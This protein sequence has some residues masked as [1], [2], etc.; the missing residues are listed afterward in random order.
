MTRSA[1]QP[2]ARSKPLS[3]LMISPEATPFA[4]TGGLGDVAG[5]LPQAL[6]RLGHRVTLV[7]PRYRGIDAGSPIDQQR[8][9]IGGRPFDVGYLEHPLAEKARA[10]FVDVPELYDRPGLYSVGDRDYPDNALRFAVL[11]RAALELGARM[12]DAWRPSLVHAHEWQAGLVPVYLKTHYARHPR[13][14]GL[15]IVFTIH[16][17]AFQGLFPSETMRSLDLGWE[18]YTPEAL[19]FWG[20]MSFLKGGVN[21]ADRITTVSPRYAREIVSPELGFNFD[22]I[23]RARQAVLSGILNGIDAEGWN[24]ET[25]VHLP[26][27]FGP[28][29][30]DTKREVKRAL[31]E[32]LRLPTDQAALDRPVVGLVSRMTDQKGFDLLGAAMPDLMALDVTFALLGS[33]E[34]RYERQWVRLAA[35]HPARVGAQIAF[36]ESLAHLIVAGADM[37]L[38]PSRF[39]PC[40]LNQ[41]YSL[42]YGTVPVVRATG[43]LADTITN[44]SDKTGKGTG[45][46]FEEY[47]VRALV[48]ALERAIAVYN[49]TRE[50]WRALQL[51]GMAEDHSWDVSAR[52]YVK[53]YRGLF[54]KA[55]SVKPRR[56]TP[57]RGHQP[58]R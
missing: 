32:R 21:F 10:I 18:L 25:D 1:D 34:A 27:H 7:L 9:W 55:A 54:P 24:P 17:L 4:K 57:A 33:G 39:E 12:D 31:L 40:G 3:V 2:I 42:R 11:S 58:E 19:E 16:N 36:D 44:Y 13:L 30:L 35:D 23:L 50:A 56:R 6:G 41:M 22:G 28:S 46:T 38:M 43:G 5:A 20:R 15:P 45:F 26:V 48:K 52:E 8:L 47:T 14:V 29:S 37:F 51:A 49:K 53:V